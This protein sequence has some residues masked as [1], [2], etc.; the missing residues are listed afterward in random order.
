MVKNLDEAVYQVLDKVNKNTFKGGV[1]EFG[2][3]RNGVGIPKNNPNLSDE[4]VKSIADYRAKIISGEIVVP[5]EPERN[6]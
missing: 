3:A 2:L 5:V 6:R 1:V 4:I